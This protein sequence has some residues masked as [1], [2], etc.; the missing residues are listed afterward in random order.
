MNTPLVISFIT[1]NRPGV[2]EDIAALINRH[3][4]NWQESALSRL[5]GKFAGILL[6]EVPEP[7]RADLEAALAGLA[8]RG[9]RVSVEPAGHLEANG[10]PVTFSVVGADRKGIVGE[11]SHLMAR[12]GV[13]VDELHTWTE[14]APMSGETLFHAHARV[15]LPQDMDDE[16]LQAALEE[17]SDDLM[18]EVDND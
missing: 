9:I 10:E 16:A 17:L 13:S 1:D 7:A 15:T 6:A 3:D 14:S 18:V 5:G 2:I 8:E 11:I 12:R 4:G